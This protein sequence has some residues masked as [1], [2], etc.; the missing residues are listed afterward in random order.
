MEWHFEVAS[1]E[2]EFWID[3]KPDHAREASAPQRNCLPGQRPWRA[4]GARRRRFDSLYMGFERYADTA[5]DQDLWID[6]VALST[7]RVGCPV[8]K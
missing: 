3:G 6:D 2:L 8:A 7:R 5:N 4:N 1:Q